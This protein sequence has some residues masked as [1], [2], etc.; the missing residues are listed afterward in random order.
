MHILVDEVGK[1]GH[2]GDCENDLKDPPCEKEGA[3]EDHGD[4]V[5]DVVLDVSWGRLCMVCLRKAFVGSRVSG[6]VV[7]VGR[8]QWRW[9][10]SGSSS[11][12]LRVV[13]E[14]RLADSHM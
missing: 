3:G 11:R 8:G 12:V 2:N 10:E 5:L 13:E 4:G 9:W 1:Q 14:L 6:R 7:W